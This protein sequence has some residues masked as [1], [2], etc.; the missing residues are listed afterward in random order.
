VIM[1]RCQMSYKT[2]PQ[3]KHNYVYANDQQNYMKWNQ[4]WW[5]VQKHI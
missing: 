4:M 2:T 5:K 3:N 1:C